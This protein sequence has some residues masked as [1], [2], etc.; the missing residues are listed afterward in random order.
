MPPK[1]VLSL[2]DL[3]V[4]SFVTQTPESIKAGEFVLPSANARTICSYC[5]DCP[6]DVFTGCDTQKFCTGG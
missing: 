2:P 1:K 5:R 4:Q 6:T 3:K